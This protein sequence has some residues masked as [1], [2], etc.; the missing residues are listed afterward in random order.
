M[1]FVAEKL[2]ILKDYIGLNDWQDSWIP[3]KRAMKILRLNI[4]KYYTS[5]ENEYLIN[6]E[7]NQSQNLENLH[8]IQM[9][10][11]LYT[12]KVGENI[13]LLIAPSQFK[14]INIK[15]IDDNI[16]IINKML[17]VENKDAFFIAKWLRIP[18][19]QFIWSMNKYNKWITDRRI[20]KRNKIHEKINRLQNIK[21]LIQVFIGL[22][23][24]KCINAK[25]ILEFIKP[26]NL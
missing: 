16:D 21:G 22:N 2:F 8:D 23:K 9:L 20:Q 13:D 25:R 19:K 3:V 1:I 7:R 12:S 5:K 18:T 15:K 6:Q 10:F 11:D 4:K 26:C 17:Y 14:N 24:G